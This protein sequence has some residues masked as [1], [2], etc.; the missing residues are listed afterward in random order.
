MYTS[1]T[2]RQVYEKHLSSNA[3]SPLKI[4]IIETQNPINFGDSGGPVVNDN[5]ELIAV[6]T[7]FSEN[8]RLVSYC[9]D[10]DEVREFLS[11]VQ[12]HP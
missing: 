10:I 4:K 8:A 6:T 1:G 5:G 11:E 2:V 7:A 9:V 12:Y 3:G